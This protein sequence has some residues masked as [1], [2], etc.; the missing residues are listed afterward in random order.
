MKR[1][2]YILLFSI[3]CTDLFA[4]TTVYKKIAQRRDD[5]TNNTWKGKDS[6]LYTYNND[7]A[8][9]SLHSLQFSANNTWDNWYRY[10]YSFNANGKVSTQL[11]ENWNAGNWV[12]NTLYTY[13]YDVNGNV[14]QLLYEVWNGNVWNATGK[15]EYTGYNNYGKYQTEMVSAFVGGN[16]VFQSKRERS[17]LNNQTLITY[18]DKFNW[19]VTFN[20]WEKVERLFNTYTQNEIGTIT[21]LIPDTG[22]NWVPKDKY[23]YNYNLNPF[24]LIEYIAQ[25]YDTITLSWQ[26][27]S[28]VTYT[29]TANA[30]LDKTQNDMYANNNWNA[31]ARAQ[32]VYNALD[33]KIEYFTEEYNMGNWDKNERSTYS[34][35]NSLL[36]EENQFIGN[37]NSWIQNKKLQFDYD[38]NQNKIYELNENFNAGIVTPVA[39]AYYYY[40]S[41]VVQL[42]ENNKPFSS[43][44]LYPNP[45]KQSIN[46]QL[47]SDKHSQIQISIF[48]L[49]GKC[50]MVL[51]Q[52]ILVT[53]QCIQ[54]P[55]T[56]LQD[57]FYFAQIK[58]LQNHKQQAVSFQI[59]Q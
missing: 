34:Y 16:W 57:G 1:L 47:E 33:E 26:N 37:G 8:L 39:R 25:S 18:D 40:S 20:N 49:V 27:I 7:T 55:C 44:I 52:P 35:T 36:T 54:I 30:L 41:F 12:N 31:T 14:T 13:S 19:N 4:Q 38:N 43:L 5:Y 58:D 45:A 56:S 53:K 15:I 22:A 23:I 29:Y 21:R 48:D 2:F 28:R 11:R 59:Q 3:T 42:N 32:Y 51:T 9:T 6:I 10:I 50:K 17:Y 46:L 24:H